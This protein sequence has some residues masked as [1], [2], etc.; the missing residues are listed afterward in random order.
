MRCVAVSAGDGGV[1]KECPSCQELRPSICFGLDRS[2][3]FGLAPYCRQCTSK[4]QATRYATD[5]TGILAANKK[6]IN[7]NPDKV[8][9]RR[10]R[11]RAENPLYDVTWRKRNIEKNRRMARERSRERRNNDPSLKIHNAVSCS[12]RDHIS[13]KVKNGRKSFDLLGYSFSDLKAHLERLFTDGMSW[14]NYGKS[15]WE[16]DHVIPVSA[17][18]FEKPEDEDFKKCWSL[19]N[20]QPLWRRENRSKQARLHRDFQPSLVF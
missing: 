18:N 1:Y 9:E 20:L 7:A 17:H 8:A 10:R 12:I 2:R 6:W 14:E 5:N 15:G 16:I 11:Y 13:G 4:K 19:S 3:V